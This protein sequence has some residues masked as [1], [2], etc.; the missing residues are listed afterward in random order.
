MKT[1]ADIQGWFDFA[2]LYYEQ[3]R[4]YAAAHFVEVG[5]W[6]GK[7]AC[8]MGEQIRRSGHDIRFDVVDTWEGAEGDGNIQTTPEIAGGD[9]Y[10]R[11][12]QNVADCELTDLIHPMRMKS[13]EA[14]GLYP[15]ESLDFVFI[16]GDHR[17]ESVTADINAWWPKVRA[18]GILAGHDYD[19]TGPA[20]AA[21]DFAFRAQ[22]PVWQDGRCWV[23]RKPACSGAKIFLALPY[24]GSITADAAESA[25]SLASNRH[26]V[27]VHARQSS[28]LASNFN[29]LWAQALNSDCE[30]FAMLHDDQ[31]PQRFWL[32]LLFEELYSTGVDMLGVVAPIKD[33][34]GLTS[35]GIGQP[36]PADCWSPLRRLTIR[37]CCGLPSTFTA[38]DCGYPGHALLLNTGC[39]I[40]DLRNP[41]WRSKDANG[42]HRVYFTINDRL[43]EEEGAA[44]V[45]VQSED[46]FFSRR[47]YDTGLSL[48]A[49]RKVGMRH[50]GKFAFP[51][52]APWGTWEDDQDTR[53]LWAENYTENEPAT[54]PVA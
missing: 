42:D 18:G 13:I 49:T 53:S 23:A 43:Y 45:A 12:Q 21:H 51:N 1:H 26:T 31:G 38:T 2:T 34:R 17:E 14:A 37:E 46:W 5:A 24:H 54:Q 11:F 40:A 39:W 3:V 48:A 8:Y 44:K 32:D 19:E 22:I 41:K 16:D 33:A 10:E 47:A 27:E 36:N 28:L 52:Y 29:H 6:L 15:D 20:N 50:W 35:I 9:L 25:W 4:S 7:S 30:F